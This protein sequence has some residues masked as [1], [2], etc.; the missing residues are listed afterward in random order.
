MEEV[1]V[2]NYL[3]LH[4]RLRLLQI[5]HPIGPFSPHGLQWN[6]PIGPFQQHYLQIAIHLS[7]R[8]RSQST[9]Q[10]QWKVQLQ[11]FILDFLIKAWPRP[12]QSRSHDPVLVVRPMRQTRPDVPA[13]SVRGSTSQKLG[14]LE[15]I[16][17]VGKC[18]R[19]NGTEKVNSRF[20]FSQM[21]IF[22][23]L[24][25][26]RVEREA[27][28]PFFNSSFSYYLINLNAYLC[29]RSQVFVHIFHKNKSYIGS[30]DVTK[31]NLLL[32]IHSLFMN[33]PL[34]KQQ[35]G[36]RSR[37]RL[38]SPPASGSTSQHRGTIIQLLLSY[39]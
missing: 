13:E 6:V 10:H 37:S 20:C 16:N 35:A 36:L 17:S 7:S 11:G 32:F 33:S 15:D 22:T 19:W 38:P 31:I 5:Q 28:N 3:T 9:L 30:K 39:H 23:R 2:T 26:K 12:Q 24:I 8:H 21:V 18:W 14:D 4:S 27:H 29:C 34:K 1:T 25:L